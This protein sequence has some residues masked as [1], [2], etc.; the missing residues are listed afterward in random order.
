MRKHEVPSRKIHPKSHQTHANVNSDKLSAKRTGKLQ[1]GTLFDKWRQTNVH[2][3]F[4]QEICDITMLYYF[5]TW[6]RWWYILTDRNSKNIQQTN[7]AA[8]RSVP[9]WIE[10]QS[11]VN[12]CVAQTS[13]TIIIVY[14][15]SVKISILII[16]LSKTI[17]YLW[18]SSAKT[19]ASLRSTGSARNIMPE[20]S[21]EHFFTT[22]IQV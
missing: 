22:F 15:S 1:V 3:F 9:D 2:Y 17:H 19:A 8:E 10:C 18:V 12:R 11:M 20:V 14:L 6:Q 13:V 5:N 4:Y 21:H 16:R 7:D